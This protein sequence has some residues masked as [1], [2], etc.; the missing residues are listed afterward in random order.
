MSSLLRR[1][2][3]VS[4]AALAVTGVG[5]VS[6]GAATPAA[7]AAPVVGPGPDFGGHHGGPLHFGPFEI[8]RHGSLSGGFS[9]GMR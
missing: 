6:A 7:P 3:V 2:A 8:P 4:L 1:V 5:A 9:W